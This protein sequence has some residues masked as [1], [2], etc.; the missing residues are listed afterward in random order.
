MGR[1]TKLSECLFWVLFGRFVRCCRFCCVT[2]RSHRSFALRFT[3]AHT[4]TALLHLAFRFRVCAS[5]AP[6]AARTAA[7]TVPALTAACTFAILRS[8]FAD[9]FAFNVCAPGARTFV[10]L[11]RSFP[12]QT[13]F[14][15]V[16][17]SSSFGSRALPRL[18][19]FVVDRTLRLVRCDR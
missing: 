13:L 3:F 8:L 12:P 11:H 19:S 7:K 15:Y 6:A 10:F 18:L 9:L 16:L 14:V 4:R 2:R 17:R 5:F 1:F